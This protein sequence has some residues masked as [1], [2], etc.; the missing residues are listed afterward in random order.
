MPCLWFQ[1]LYQLAWLSDFHRGISRLDA[2]IFLPG[3]LTV[4]IGASILPLRIRGSDMWRVRSKFHCEVHVHLCNPVN[5]L[6]HLFNLP[7]NG[8]LNIQ[9]RA[10]IISLLMQMSPDKMLLLRDFLQDPDFFNG[11]CQPSSRIVSACVWRGPL[12]LLA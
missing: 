12:T 11:F 1:S 6:L 7:G 10:F 9:P 8:L 5:L 4:E 2:S 3:A